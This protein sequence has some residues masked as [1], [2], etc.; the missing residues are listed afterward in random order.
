MFFF[1]TKLL[2]SLAYVTFGS[3]LLEI[4]KSL[5]IVNVLIYWCYIRRCYTKT[6]ILMRLNV[7]VSSVFVVLPLILIVTRR[8]YGFLFLIYP[9]ILHFIILEF[10]LLLC[11]IE[12]SLLAVNKIFMIL[13]TLI[14]ILTL[15]LKYLNYNTDGQPICK[16]YKLRK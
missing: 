11:L 2:I 15:V 1:I 13:F 10:L 16:K 5:L 3:I 9:S 6:M 12:N 7:A 8:V 4:W 14:S